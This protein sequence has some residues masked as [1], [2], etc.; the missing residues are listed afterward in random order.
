MPLIREKP[1]PVDWQAEAKQRL[2]EE[3]REWTKTYVSACL[4][5]LDLHDHFEVTVPAVAGKRNGPWNS[6]EW[7][8]VGRKIP[9]APRGFLG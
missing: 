7:Y 2:L 1:K 6:L 8:K 3:E 9:W 5:R 4:R